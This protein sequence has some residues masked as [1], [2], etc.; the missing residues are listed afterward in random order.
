M[1]QIKNCWRAKLK[2]QSSS[3]TALEDAGFLT[4]KEQEEFIRLQRIFIFL[5]ILTTLF[6]RTTLGFYSISGM[7]PLILIAASLSY[8][9]S[10][11]YLAI[12]ARNFLQLIEFHLPI[13]ME[14]IVMAVESGLD[15]IPAIGVILELENKKGVMRDQSGKDPV[16]K[17]LDIVY[18]LSQAGMPFEQALL[19][20]SSR[21]KSHALKHAFVHL[22]LA[23]RE[24]G[25]LLGPLREL[26][27]ATQLYY[28]ESIE[29]EIAKMP[30]KATM[31]LVLTFAGLMIFFISTPLVQ[32]SN[33]TE[34]AISHE[35]GIHATP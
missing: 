32:I 11:Y 3:N 1:S 4:L 22:G 24:G 15:V 34:G 21:I 9:A 25:E 13:V 8:L 31:P 20:A 14:R 29:L 33:I 27:D 35:G 28:Q 26:S 10:R 7:L 6:A 17:I 2:N 19:D 12:A 23:Q 5:T 30:V 16:T 18:K